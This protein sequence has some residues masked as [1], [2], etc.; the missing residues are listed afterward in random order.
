MHSHS[1]PA[2]DWRKANDRVTGT[3]LAAIF[4]TRHGE[5]LR[6]VQGVCDNLLCRG[7]AACCAERLK[8]SAQRRGRSHFSASY[9]TAPSST[10]TADCR[11][12]YPRPLCSALIGQAVMHDSLA[13]RIEDH[14]AVRTTLQSK[15]ACPRQSPPPEG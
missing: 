12:D 15:T 2:A 8:L 6:T 5:A 9:H 13:A 1:R 3:Y 7:F 10:S 4:A 14:G 11:R